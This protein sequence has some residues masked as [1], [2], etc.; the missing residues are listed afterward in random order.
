MAFGKGGNQNKSQSVKAKTK[1]G[2]DKTDKLKNLRK[3]Q[4]TQEA[5]KPRRRKKKPRQ[6]QNRKIAKTPK[7]LTN[8]Q[9]ATLLRL[10]IILIENSSHSQQ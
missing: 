10:I 8:L 2:N 7:L 6:S 1:R 5:Q 9:S 3:Q 4:E